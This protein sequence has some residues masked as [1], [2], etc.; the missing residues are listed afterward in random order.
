MKFE[1]YTFLREH[2]TAKLL[3]KLEAD[4]EYSC[5]EKDRYAV[6]DFRTGLQDDTKKLHK[7]I[8]V[9]SLGNGRYNYIFYDMG[10]KGS[11]RITLIKEIIKSLWM[12]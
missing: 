1:D 10:I 8:N 3:E 2:R 12:I 9:I 11:E 6:R 7:I 4:Y 5:P